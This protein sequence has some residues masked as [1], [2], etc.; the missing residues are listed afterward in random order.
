MQNELL[1]CGQLVWAEGLSMRIKTRLRSGQ[2][3]NA[4]WPVS[5]IRILHRKDDNIVFSIPRWLANKEALNANSIIPP[6]NEQD[7]ATLTSIAARLFYIEERVLDQAERR[8][9]KLGP[10]ADDARNRIVQM[11]DRVEKLQESFPFPLAG[12]SVAQMAL[13]TT[14]I[15]TA[16]KTL[17]NRSQPPSKE[18]DK[19]KRPS[20][21]P[22]R[23][24]R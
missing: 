21:P 1:A 23:V 9:G 7:K 11:R 2:F 22:A 15:E 10:K 12:P 6:L 16:I 3:H 8:N 17:I 4:F 13:E 18:E 19:T 20:S 14:R 5:R 24:R